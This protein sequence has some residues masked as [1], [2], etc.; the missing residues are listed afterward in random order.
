MTPAQIKKAQE[1]LDKRKTL[2]TLYDKNSKKRGRMWVL[3]N[4]KFTLCFSCT[5][6][7]FVIT[8]ETLERWVKQAKKVKKM[9]ILK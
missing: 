4:D 6:D 9:G 2:I 1:I 8:L 3:P 5:E 7:T